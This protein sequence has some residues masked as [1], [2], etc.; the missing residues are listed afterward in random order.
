M[1]TPHNYIFG[2]RRIFF[3]DPSVRKDRNT[4]IIPALFKPCLDKKSLAEC[5]R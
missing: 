3:A 1:A 5:A 4:Q 2:L